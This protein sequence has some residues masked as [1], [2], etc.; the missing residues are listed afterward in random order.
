V[1]SHAYVEKMGDQ[2][3][4]GFIN[5]LMLGNDSKR[6][7]KEKKI[8]NM[9]LYLRSPGE[10]G[11]EN[12]LKLASLIFTNGKR[13][14]SAIEFKLEANGMNSSSHV[15]FWEAGHPAI[16]LSQNWE[17]DFNPRF[18][19]SNDFVETLNMNTYVNA[20]RY[21]AGAVLAWNYDIVK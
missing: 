10:K 15:N 1:G 16:C 6:D 5:L 20:F 12:D 13:L 11:N 19:T 21:I 8:N 4:S 14:Y 9:K 18:H 2:K 7:D 3:I 17:S